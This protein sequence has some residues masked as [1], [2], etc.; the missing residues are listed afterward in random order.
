MASCAICGKKRIIGNN[1]S[2]SNNKTKRIIMP[3]LQRIR[4]FTESG[5]KRLRICTRCIRSGKV[6]KAV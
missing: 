5:V 4:V 1:V 3:N 2:H 6:K